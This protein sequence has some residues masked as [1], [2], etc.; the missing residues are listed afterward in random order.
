MPSEAELAPF[1]RFAVAPVTPRLTLA[2]IR[3]TVTPLLMVEIAF[4]T[5]SISSLSEFVDGVP[6]AGGAGPPAGDGPSNNP[7][8]LTV[9]HR[10]T[11]WRIASSEIGLM[12]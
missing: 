7:I 3:P 9:A 1:F 2:P 5:A 12:L 4:L 10:T 6:G 8:A 11:T